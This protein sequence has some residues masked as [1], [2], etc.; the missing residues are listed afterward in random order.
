MVRVSVFNKQGQ[1][2][3]PVDLPRVELTDDQWQSRLSPEE[4]KIAQ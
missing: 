1:L 2:V 3:G 4:Y